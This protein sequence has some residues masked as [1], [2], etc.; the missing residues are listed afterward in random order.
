MLQNI[1]LKWDL[2][3]QA[4]INCFVSHKESLLHIGW[5]HDGE[6]LRVAWNAYSH[7]LATVKKVESEQAQGPTTIDAGVSVVDTLWFGCRKMSNW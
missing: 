5:L 7:T 6:L 3:V 4:N 2:F 1:S